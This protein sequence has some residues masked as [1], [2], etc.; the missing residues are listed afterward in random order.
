MVYTLSF[1]MKTAMY[2]WANGQKLYAIENNFQFEFPRRIA[3]ELEKYL[4][5]V[6]THSPFI[7]SEWFLSLPS[8]DRLLIN[9][10]QL[11]CPLR[12]LND[13]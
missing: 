3:I 9:V 13:Y 10:R 8:D 11:N 6:N 1:A 4:L 12:H 5:E 2:W 7:I